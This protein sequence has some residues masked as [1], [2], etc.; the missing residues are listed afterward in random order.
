MT[1]YVQYTHVHGVQVCTHFFTAPQN[2]QTHSRAH[3]HTHTH[4]HTHTH[5]H[6]KYVPVFIHINTD[7]LPKPLESSVEKNRIH[8]I[9]YRCPYDWHSYTA[10]THTHTHMRVR[11]HAHT[12]TRA[13][14]HTSTYVTRSDKKGLIACQILTI[15]SRFESL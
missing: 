15:I 8:G 10:H 12:H 1:T 13:R 11:E 14:T 2:T 7:L 4:V 3:T 5:T 6:Y 9:N